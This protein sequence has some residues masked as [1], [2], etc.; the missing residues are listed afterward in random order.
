MEFEN[1]SDKI[2]MRKKICA[3]FALL[4]ISI[5]IGIISTTRDTY[6]FGFFIIGI[7]FLSMIVIINLHKDNTLKNILVLAFFIRLIL[8]IVGSYIMPFPDTSQDAALFERRGQEIADA[9]TYGTKIPNTPGGLYYYSRVVA[10]IFYFAGNTT[11]LAIFLNLILSIIIIFFVYKL[12]L[13]MG[14][15]KKFGH[16]GS[17]FAAL[18]PTLNI[19]SV[20]LLRENLITLSI[21][22]SFYYLIKWLRTGGKAEIFMSSTML[23]LGSVFH[24]AINIIALVY[25][26]FFCFY[27]TKTRK[28]RFFS[29]RVIV[30]VLGIVV[31][32]YFFSSKVMNKLPNN[33][34]LLI[35]P[36]Y[37]TG[38]IKLLAVGRG[39]YLIDYFP[40]S[41]FD[42]FWQ[43]PIRILYFLFTPFPWMISVAKDIVGFGDS[44]MIFVLF[45]LVF[46]S[47]I[48]LLN[49]NRIICVAITLV[50][51]SFLIMFSWGT[52]NYGTAIRHRTKIVPLLIAI[53]M[54][55]LDN[56]KHT[57]SKET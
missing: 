37:F 57:N 19:Y 12:I 56:K 40:N 36:Q 8:L 9:W 43:T 16:I 7:I 35:S 28:W 44:V 23:L 41:M 5:L 14:C 22:I 48:R 21:L 33:I 38:R 4:I 11:F 42:L 6:F 32:A 30:G 2:Y 18:F 24:G 53:S 1:K 39:A 27:N 46:I 20:V 50:L 45:C 51:M 25:A 54:V 47:L 49:K 52:S 29:R 15:S 34:M 26:L 31:I 10:W 55:S 3:F 13:E 17:V